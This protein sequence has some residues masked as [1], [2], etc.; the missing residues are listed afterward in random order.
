MHYFINIKRHLTLTF[1]AFTDNLI[2]ET[3][4]LTHAIKLLLADAQY[5]QLQ[6][7]APDHAYSV[8]FLIFTI[9]LNCVEFMKLVFGKLE[10]QPRFN[11]CFWFLTFFRL[12]YL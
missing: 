4:Q 11:F 5:G 1:L 12:V 7:R 10:S 2:A 8:C 9:L 3:E 6:A